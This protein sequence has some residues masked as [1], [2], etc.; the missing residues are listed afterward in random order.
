MPVTVEEH[1][2]RYRKLH[3]DVRKALQPYFDID[4]KSVKVKLIDYSPTTTIWTLGDVIVVKRGVLNF[5]YKS[6]SEMRDGKLWH[7]GNGALDLST[8]AGIQ[9]LAHEIK[10]CEQWRLIPRW[11]YLLWYLPGVVR[12]WLAGRRYAHKYIRWERD[13]IAFQ[14]TV[15]LSDKQLIDF[16]K[17]QNDRS[18]T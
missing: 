15:K 6:T 18:D 1:A 10:H 5:E 14:K 16:K 17:L 4:L 8:D 3:P 2:E 13:A 7:T 12:G 11:K 9:V